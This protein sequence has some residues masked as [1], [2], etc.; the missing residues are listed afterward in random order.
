VASAVATREDR[1]RDMIE[2]GMKRTEPWTLDIPRDIHAS[3]ELGSDTTRRASNAAVIGRSAPLLTQFLNIHS[4]HRAS[5]VEPNWGRN[6][7]SN[8]LVGNEKLCARAGCPRK[9]DAICS[10]A[11]RQPS[12]FR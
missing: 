2:N 3:P 8:G 6:K 5:R 7:R 11:H 1:I 10:Y 12:R 9:R 4:C